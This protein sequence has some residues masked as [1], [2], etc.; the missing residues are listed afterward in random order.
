MQNWLT[1]NPKKV[2]TG[3]ETLVAEVPPE[4]GGVLAP[5]WAPQ[6][7]GHMPGRG[8]PIPSGCENQ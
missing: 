5:H 3:R 8:I 7:R 6:P 2:D 4:E 1:P